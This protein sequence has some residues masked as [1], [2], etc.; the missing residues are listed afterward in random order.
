MPLYKVLLVDDEE[1]VRQAIAQKLNW[2][3]LGFDVVGEASNGIEAL[4][5]AEKLEPDVIMTDIKM[6][7]MDGLTFCKQVRAI[8]P[9]V[10]LAVFSGFGEFDYAREA[11]NQQV[12]EYIL[13]PINA[14]ELARTF[15][16]IRDSLDQEIS[17]RRNVERLRSHYNESL[18]LLRQQL[19]RSLVE[20]QTSVPVATAKLAEYGVDLR[21][22][23]YCVAIFSFDTNQNDEQTSLLSLSLGQLIE[24]SLSQIVSFQMLSYPDSFALLFLLNSPQRDVQQHL[25]TFFPLSKKLLGIQISIGLSR[26]Y[27]SPN[28]IPLCYR[29]AK[30]A[31][32]YQLIAEPNHCIYIGDIEPGETEMDGFDDDITENILRQ[33]KIGDETSLKEAVLAL[34]DTLTMKHMSMQN[35]Q[36]V[37]LSLFTELLKLIRSYQLDVDEARQN[38]LL[39]ESA[40]MRVSHREE[41]SVWLYDY[42]ANLQNIVR[43]ERRN[44]ALVLVDRSKNLIASQYADCDLSLDS[45]SAQ[46]N[47]SPAYVS[48]LFKKETGQGFVSYLTQLRMEHA[49]TLLHQTDDK[50]YQIAEKIGY[51]DPNYFSY[52]FKRHFGVSPSKYR[53]ERA[54]DLHD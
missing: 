8:L 13:K 1:N 39:A 29:E 42:C 4:E 46:L 30:N 9:T 38:E 25:D 45:L 16:R 35:C 49:I 31:L 51:A 52:V 14:E 47:M 33:I 12:S 2:N 54:K 10:H 20:G 19:L 41:F 27:E 6:P 50:T 3:E 32:E 5:L 11:M 48:S 15:M 22:K 18:P 43:R 7:F 21:A 17:A 28:E 53:S 23:S 34:I 37:L 44:S 24:E 36:I 40:A 26:A